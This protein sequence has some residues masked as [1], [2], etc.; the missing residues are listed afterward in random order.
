MAKHGWTVQSETAA[1][2]KDRRRTPSEPRFRS[3]S[4]SHRHSVFACGP[5]RESSSSSDSPPSFPVSSL[6]LISHQTLPLQGSLSLSLS[7]FLSLCLVSSQSSLP[8]YSTHRYPQPGS[9]FVPTSLI[10]ASH[11]HSLVVLLAPEQA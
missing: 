5:S 9:F 7:L 2:A 1:A 6:F 8:R 3:L 4:P 10:R 11:S